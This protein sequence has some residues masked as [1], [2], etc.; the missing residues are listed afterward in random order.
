M[1]QTVFQLLLFYSTA[2][3]AWRTIK[4]LRS[5][6]HKK[7]DEHLR[8]EP[9]YE[10]LQGWVILSLHHLMVQLQMEYFVRFVPFYFHLKIVALV[11]LFIVPS[12]SPKGRSEYGL[13]PFISYLFEYVIV[14]GVQRVHE[15][16]DNDP[17]EYMLKHL[18]M[19]PLVLIDLFFLPGVLTAVENKNEV[20]KFESNDGTSME[21]GTKPTCS[22]TDDEPKTPL[23]R[24]SSTPATSRTCSMTDDAPKT[25][26]R[27]KSSTPATRRTPSSNGF[28]SSTSPSVK[29]RLESSAK[30]LKR[31]SH[32]HQTSGETLLCPRTTPRKGETLS[33]TEERRNGN[34]ES[35]S[36][37]RTRRQRRGRLSLGDHVREIVCGDRRVRVRDHLFD[38]ELPSTPRKH[39]RAG[40]GRANEKI[41]AT[42]GATESDVR[43][44]AHVTRR[45]SSRLSKRKVASAGTSRRDP[46]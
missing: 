10:I 34:T 5:S 20:E 24:K 14:Y 6:L 28:K 3:L 44:D 13:S 45:R 11:A 9:E 16:M 26:L 32:D 33:V 22:M 27:R 2:R 17:K 15:L 18:A 37:T 4:S 25:P 40:P 8:A 35:I 7:N 29:S 31:F 38:L 46:L 19:L 43:P 30:R 39:L 36:T 1:A 23:R 41:R 42:G 21:S 12:R